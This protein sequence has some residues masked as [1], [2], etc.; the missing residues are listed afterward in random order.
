MRFYRRWQAPTIIS[1]DLDDTL[2][3]NKPVLLHAEQQLQHYLIAQDERLAD[4][5]LSDWAQLRKQIAHQAPE[6]AH[7]MT[8]LRLASIRHTLSTLG[9]N[10][11][12]ALRHA[13]H[14]MTLFLA[15]RNH[16]QLTDDV[17][18]LMQALAA[19]Y[20]LVA[21]TNGNADPNQFGLQ[22]IFQSHHY[23]GGG[24]RMKPYPD[25]FHQAQQQHQRY[26][27]AWLHI[28]DHPRT[29]VQ[30]ALAMQWQTCWLNQRPQRR[31]LHHLP[32]VE[33]HQLDA[34]AS[35]LL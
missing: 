16:I 28:G 17:I 27:A 10:R 29:D 21:I 3:D 31:P 15:E 32:H 11:I 6:L 1:F 9:H 24:I 35:L 19:R 13:E 22:G 23:A 12:D 33:I 7:D 4:W 2:Y 5:Q 26:G 18:A 20:P 34:L 8:A 30:G 14:A 25:M